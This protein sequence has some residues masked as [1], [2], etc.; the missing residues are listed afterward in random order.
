[1]WIPSVQVQGVYEYVCVCV[2]VVWGTYAGECGGI[3]LPVEA[4]EG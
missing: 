4:R 1:M 2:C 3:F